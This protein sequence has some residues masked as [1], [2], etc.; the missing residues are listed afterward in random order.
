MKKGKRKPYSPRDFHLFNLHRRHNR[1]CRRKG[2]SNG[3]HSSLILTIKLQTHIH[4]RTHTHTHCTTPQHTPHT[5]HT[6]TAKHGHVIEPEIGCPC[7]SYCP[8]AAPL[9]PSVIFFFSCLFLKLVSVYL[10]L[11]LFLFL[12][13]PLFLC[14]FA[15]C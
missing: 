8:C 7:L 9:F 10:S 13:L 12:S 15:F 14:L 3:H 11:F 5:Q 2:I 4:T 1:W 6:Q